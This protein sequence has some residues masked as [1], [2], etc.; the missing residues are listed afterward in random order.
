MILTIM[1]FQRDAYRRQYEETQLE[2]AEAKERIEWDG[3]KVNI[4]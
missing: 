4:Y 3:E 2:L 1:Y